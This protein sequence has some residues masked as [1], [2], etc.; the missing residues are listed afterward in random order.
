MRGVKNKRMTKK[1]GRAS[2]DFSTHQDNTGRW[3]ISGMVALCS[4]LS[5]PKLK[6]LSGASYRDHLLIS[7]SRRLTYGTN[8]TTPPH[9]PV[10]QWVLGVADSDTTPNT[11]EAASDSLSTTLILMSMKCIA[12]DERSKR[13]PEFYLEA[14]RR[15]NWREEQLFWNDH[16]MVLGVAGGVLHYY[17]MKARIYHWK[18]FGGP[19]IKFFWR[20]PGRDMDSRIAQLPGQ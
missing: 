4:C 5:K 14:P 10:W 16:V 1:M 9:A 12:T 3:I 19:A 13:Q 18:H 8:S 2:M 6:S 20:R 11:T 7:A 17:C 15:K